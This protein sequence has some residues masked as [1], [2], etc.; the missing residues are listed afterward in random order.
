M[1][2]GSTAASALI[3]VCHGFTINRTGPGVADG[4]IGAAGGVFA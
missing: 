3:H 1:I 2:G 4:H